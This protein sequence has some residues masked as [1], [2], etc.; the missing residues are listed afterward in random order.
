MSSGNTWELSFGE[1]PAFQ[2]L[3]DPPPSPRVFSCWLLW[4]GAVAA[5]VSTWLPCAEREVRAPEQSLCVCDSFLP[6]GKERMGRGSASGPPG[7][8]PVPPASPI[9]NQSPWVLYVQAHSPAGQLGLCSEWILLGFAATLH[10]F[11][12]LGLYC[13]HLGQVTEAL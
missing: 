3:I 4:L 2:T 10:R 5:A 6:T 1:I 9:C 8:E 11:S 13:P 12:G 7:G